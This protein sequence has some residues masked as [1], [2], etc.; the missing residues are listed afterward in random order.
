MFVS[1]LIVEGTARHAP[2]LGVTSQKRTFD[3]PR[4]NMDHEFLYRECVMWTAVLA[5]IVHDHPPEGA[6]GKE[7]RLHTLT[8]RVM[9]VSR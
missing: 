6:G 2:Q 8:H 3:T 5:P 9:S 4:G 1:V 7:A